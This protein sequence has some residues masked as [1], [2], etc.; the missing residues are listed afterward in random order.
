MF[1]EMEKL[2][3]SHNFQLKIYYTAVDINEINYI[4]IGKC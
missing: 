3:Y 4:N 1:V 2:L